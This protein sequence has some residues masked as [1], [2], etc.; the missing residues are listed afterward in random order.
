M[1]GYG[2]NKTGTPAFE[3]RGI[4]EGFYGQPWS[5]G[6]RLDMIAFI[7][8]RGMNTFVYAPKDDPL[9]RRDWRV[10]YSGEQLARLAELIAQCK[11]HHVDFLYC[12]SPGLS[13]RYSSAD[14]VN[15]LTAK[16]ESVMRIGAAGVGLLLDDI[17]PVLQYDDDLAAWPTLAAAHV[18][19]ANGLAARFPGLLVCPT[20]Y[21]GTGTEEYITVF[22]QG[23]HPTARLFFTGRLVCSPFIDLRDA[24]V[25]R[26]STSHAPLYWDNYPV[27]DVAMTHE[28]H[29]GPY[30][31][32]DPQLATVALGV[33]ANGMQYAQSSK[34]AFATVADYLWSPTDYDPQRSWEVAVAD[35]VG[36]PADV[37]AYRMFAE[38]SLTSCLNLDDAL[39]FGRTLERFDFLVEIGRAEQAAVELAEYAGRL[40]AASDHL[41]SGRVTNTALVAEAMPWLESFR[42]GAE[43]LTVMAQL[44]AAGDLETDG[45]IA[46]ASFRDELVANRRRV[47]GD[48]LD[49]A[50]A[51]IVSP[52]T[53]RIT[54][55][56]HK[57]ATS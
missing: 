26:D 23:L 8:E 3:M 15:A 16:L 20:Q 53:P 39:E 49:M 31:G 40:R 51:E 18:E 19:L 57:E 11:T 9:M 21:Y 42:I 4:V 38:N 50:L 29:I 44:A 5:H 43:A 1:T 7:A 33:I 45:P 27:N 24:Q 35:I 2:V 36:D 17:P 22:G 14:D 55:T 46:L 12:L 10:E 32:R 34:I 30:R 37:H 54:V 25:F 47:F 48:S 52:I 28:L 13:I 56:T 41:L 6:E